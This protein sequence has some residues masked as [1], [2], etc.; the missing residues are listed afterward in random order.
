MIIWSNPGRLAIANGIAAR[1]VPD[2]WRLKLYAND[3]D[4]EAGS[5]A[6]DFM[7]PVFPGYE[8]ELV[9]PFEPATINSDGNAE[10]LATGLVEITR[11]PEPAPVAVAEGFFVVNAGGLLVFAE[12]FPQVAVFANPHD[13]IRIR[14]PVVVGTCPDDTDES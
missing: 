2:G 1:S 3:V 7:E 13:V 5:V 8:S 11:G 6:G 14:I 12:R 9:G 10:A 4:P